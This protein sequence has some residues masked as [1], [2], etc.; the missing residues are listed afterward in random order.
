MFSLFVL[1]CCAFVI[2][3]RVSGRPRLALI[4]YACLLC[5]L[6]SRF[7]KNAWF[8]YFFKFILCIWVLCSLQTHQKRA[9]DPIT[10]GCEPPCGLLTM[11]ELNSGP[12]EEQSVFFCLFVCLF[13]LCFGAGDRTQGF[14]LPRQAL[15]HWAKSLTPQSVFL[16]TKLS[17]QPPIHLFLSVVVSNIL[18]ALFVCFQDRASLCS[19]DYPGMHMNSQKSAYL[20]QP[21]AGIKGENS[22]A[23]L[24]PWCFLFGGGAWFCYLKD[25]LF[26]HNLVQPQRTNWD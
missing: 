5:I 4:W 24:R 23:L 9:S 18:L 15:Y 26:L 20:W 21:G 22:Y 1:L 6:S 17:L 11:W 7:V 12:L 8:I 10:D 2:W 25:S 14:A 3:D 19:S 13:V 16:T